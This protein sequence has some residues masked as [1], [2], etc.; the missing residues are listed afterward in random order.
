[1]RIAAER[2]SV[3]R[4]ARSPTDEAANISILGCKGSTYGDIPEARMPG[5]EVS[6]AIRAPMLATSGNVINPVILQWA[7]SNSRL[8]YLATNKPNDLVPAHRA[9]L[10]ALADHTLQCVEENPAKGVVLTAYGAGE[11]I[12]GLSDAQKKEVMMASAEEFAK[13]VKAL[14][15]KGIEVSYADTSA[16]AAFWDD[17]Q[18][19]LG[20]VKVPMTY[21]GQL[22]NDKVD[23]KIV[24][25]SGS[26]TSLVGG[27]WEKGMKS[28]SAAMGQHSLVQSIH[29]GFCAAINAGM[30]YDEVKRLDQG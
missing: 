11:S 5:N 10:K 29:A 27:G 30:S 13:L 14:H 2:D 25:V 4:D 12:K 21:I 26:S 3:R 8:A 9:T 24:V 7:A 20:G 1:M 23:N 22:P 16:Y 17:V 15:K 19:A 28:G 18:L 6:I